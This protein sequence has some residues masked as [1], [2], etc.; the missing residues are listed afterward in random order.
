[1]S[2][3]NPLFNIVALAMGELCTPVGGA[4]LHKHRSRGAPAHLCIILYEEG[5]QYR[6]KEKQTTIHSSSREQARQD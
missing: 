4:A 6:K 3:T 2:G 1:M 5:T